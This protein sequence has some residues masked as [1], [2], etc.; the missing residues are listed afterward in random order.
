MSI[1]RGFGRRAWGVVGGLAITLG[2]FS[3]ACGDDDDGGP[4]GPGEGGEGGGAGSGTAQRLVILHTNDLHSHLMGHAPERDY[5]P[6]TTGDDDTRGGMAR[7]ASAVA[8]ARARAEAA[9]TPVL[10]L[11]AGDFMMGTPFELLATEQAPELA[12][13]Q[14]LGYDATTIGNHEL[15]WTPLGLAGILQAA[16]ARGVSV[17]I[18]ASNMQFSDAEADDGLEALADAGVIRTKLVRTV[19]SLKVG[20]FGLLG[21]DAVQV[22][23]QAAPLEF[24]PPEQAAERMVQEL[25][26]TDGVDL[27]IALSHSGIDADGEGED[28]V[29]AR[30]VSGIDV[31]VSGHTHEWLEEP[32]RVGNTWIVT[33]GAYG[34]F[35]GELELT[36]TPSAT[37]GAPPGLVVERYTLRDIDD[38]IEGDAEIQ[39]QVEEYIDAVD[40]RLAAGG[41]SYRQVI[42]TTEVDLPL[43]RYAEAPLGNLVTDAYR[44]VT[45]ALQPTDPPLIGVDANGQLRAPLVRGET[46]EVWFAD[47]FRVLPLGIGPDGQPGFPLVTFHLTPADIRAGLELGA[48]KDAISND[49]FLQV[50]GLEVEYDPSQV[51]LNRV[52]SL[53]LVTSQGRMAL[54]LDDTETCYPVVTTAYVAGLLGLVEGVTGGLLAVQARDADCTPIADAASRFVDADPE[55]DGVQ[56]LKHWQALLQYVSGLPDTD[57][58]GVPNIPAAYGSAQG[59]IVER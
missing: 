8:E 11:D 5:T 27:V 7:L 37:A 40:Q 46:G 4:A 36:V 21:R 12:L 23:P 58:D 50:S 43:P 35:L 10:L 3:S 15:D 47:L 39:S 54:D 1:Q 26:E 34:E 53:A 22:T 32:V 41:L 55:R 48:L 24:E 49:L 2:L 51:G 18:L 30:A 25:R 19:G 29:L 20:L 31:I 17:P 13:F 52:A 45:A 42:A 28:A 6:E 14:A 44:V 56:E 16:S 38:S 59:R 57:G 33:A 9:D